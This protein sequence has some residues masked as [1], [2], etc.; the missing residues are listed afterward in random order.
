MAEQANV[1]VKNLCTGEINVKRKLPDP[2]PA[3]TIDKDINIANGG[4]EQIQLSGTDVLLI[5][6]PPA[7][8]EMKNYYIKV[9]S[10]ID[11]A[12]PCSRTDSNWTIK[13]KPNDLPPDSP[14]DVNVTMGGDE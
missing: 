8:G 13:I 12:V 5:I 3:G 4:Q 7:G 1:Y 6:S 11:L 10:D 9:R 2:P 14:L